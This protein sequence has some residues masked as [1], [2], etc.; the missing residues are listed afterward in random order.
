MTLSIPQDSVK[1]TQDIKARI[2]NGEISNHGKLKI[3]NIILEWVRQDIHRYKK[4]VRL[5]R[6]VKKGLRDDFDWVCAIVGT[7]GVG[8]SSL[9]IILGAL[10]D[11]GF[12]LE[13][14]LSLLPSTGEIQRKFK[15]LKKYGVLG[16]DEAIKALHKQDWYNDMQKAL[17]HM[18]ATERF[19]NKATL[20]AIPRFYDLNENFRNHRVNCR[21]NVAERGRAL[22]Y[23][24][25]DVEYF[26]DPWFMDEMEKIYR[27]VLRKKKVTEL[28]FEDKVQIEKRN[29]PS[30][31]DDIEFPDL[32][33]QVKEVYI[34]AK[35][36]SRKKEDKDN[37]EELPKDKFRRF[38][39]IQL[40]KESQTMTQK[41]IA[42]KNGLTLSMVKSLIKEGKI[43][44]REN[45]ESV[46][47]NKG[48]K[49]VP[50][51]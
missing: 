41:V 15:K 19:Q 51:Q 5:S 3:H 22:V 43:W 38:T 47:L 23:I 35:V 25:V 39:A 40:F 9:L 13:R 16:L 10:I 31:L 2:A 44:M 1:E 18:Y 32:P 46:E 27:R 7:E 42:E 8:K 28:T 14:N 37:I 36:E 33:E 26:R 4:L 49:D 24:K 30:F 17:V 12:I 50:F 45:K 34:N 20:M 29:N 6:A 48:V 11:M 21:I